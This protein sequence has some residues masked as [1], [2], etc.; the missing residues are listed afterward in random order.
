[1][2]RCFLL[3]AGASYGCHKQKSPPS[4]QQP[5][6]GEYL[7]NDGWKTGLLQNSDFGSLKE[8]LEK[9]PDR[10]LPINKP[11]DLNMN[12]EL[13]LRQIDNHINALNAYSLYPSIFEGTVSGSAIQKPDFLDVSYENTYELLRRYFHELD[14]QKR[15]SI[16]VVYYYLYELFRR[17]TIQYQPRNDYYTM[18]AN[19]LDSNVPKDSVLSLNYDAM[20]EKAIHSIHS[21]YHYSGLRR[22]FSPRRRHKMR[23]IP[24]AKLHGSVNWKNEFSSI[25]ITPRTFET[26]AQS[27]HGNRQFQNIEY[28]SFEELDST[29]Y[30]DLMYKYPVQYEP[31]V[32]PPL[33]GGKDYEKTSAYEKVWNAAGTLL[34][35]A[36]EL[37]VIGSCL[38]P[39]D[40]KLL[41]L[42][43]SHM[44]GG[45]VITIV[46]GSSSSD[47][48]RRLEKRLEGPDIETE[49]M[50]F[51]E[52]MDSAV[53]S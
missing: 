46:S 45:D 7:F 8:E 5:P 44:T 19:H 49:C 23:S 32:I 26:D 39:H 50:K 27:I 40:E 30:R 34:S 21:D 35:K 10:K 9:P 17:Y 22:G 20:F 48:K 51:G 6:T 53:S 42:I 3:G 12:A 11:S 38:S 1:M 43:Q 28:I 52:Y 18:L 41:D 33:E 47:I 16:G 36:T 31:V 29:N 13:F 4:D 25:K 24:I 37:V 2:S 15:T 14:I